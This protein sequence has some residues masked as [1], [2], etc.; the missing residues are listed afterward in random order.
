MKQ[1]LGIF[2]QYVSEDYLYFISNEFKLANKEGY[3]NLSKIID[4][5]TL[6]STEEEQEKVK[7]NIL[8]DIVQEIEEVGNISKFIKR[9]QICRVSKTI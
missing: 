7:Y 1:C 3:L 5:L 8:E 2:S 4:W 9:K 6:K